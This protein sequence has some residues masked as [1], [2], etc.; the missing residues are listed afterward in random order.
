G[1]HDDRHLPKHLT[2]ARSAK[3]RQNKPMTDDVQA[4]S[5]KQEARSKKQQATSNKQQATSNKQQATSNKQQATSNKQRATYKRRQAKCKMQ[6]ATNKRDATSNTQ[7]GNK[8]HATS[9]NPA[10]QRW[11]QHL[12]RVHVG[13]KQRLLLVLDRLLHAHTPHLNHV[14]LGVQ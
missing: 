4:T 3:Y 13:Q 12:G 9:S 6:H 11:P 2:L 14:H 10:Q 1:G 5:N 7:H 8:Q